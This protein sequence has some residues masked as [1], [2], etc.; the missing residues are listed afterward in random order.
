MK[1]S[2]I[3]ILAKNLGVC[4]FLERAPTP[5]GTVRMQNS[6]NSRKSWTIFRLWNM[7]KVNNNF[8]NHFQLFRSILITLASKCSQ[9]VRKVF[10]QRRITCC[11][12]AAFL[13]ARTAFGLI[14]LI[15]F[16]LIVFDIEQGWPFIEK[17]EARAILERDWKCMD[18]VTEFWLNGRNLIRWIWLLE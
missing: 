9:N 4:H 17:L 2:N 5:K 3:L 6:F 13:A 7:S 11:P 12:P 15:L 8:T 1:Y 14:N 16:D 18:S 10:A